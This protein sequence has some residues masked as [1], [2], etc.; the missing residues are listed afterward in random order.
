MER[1]GYGLGR[2]LD[3]IELPEPEVP[4]E[5]V[6]QENVPHNVQGE[7]VQ[8]PVQQNVQ[9][10]AHNVQQQENPKVNIIIFLMF[11]NLYS[12]FSILCF[13]FRMLV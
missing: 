9:G 7:A 10:E 13:L 5:N 8:Q 1:K 4:Q 6:P 2:I 3:R 11:R 12:M